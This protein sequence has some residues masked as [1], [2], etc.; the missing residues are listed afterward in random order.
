MGVD[1]CGSRTY[2]Q[3]GDSRNYLLDAGG[4]TAAAAAV[5]DNTIRQ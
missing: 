5:Q 1:E 3:Y 4:G 2:S